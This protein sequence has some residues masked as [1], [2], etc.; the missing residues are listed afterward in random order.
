[1]SMSGN[2]NNKESERYRQDLHMRIGSMKT[3][4]LKLKNLHD[5]HTLGDVGDLN[6]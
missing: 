3:Q 1:M 6:T 2:K 4:K 5:S